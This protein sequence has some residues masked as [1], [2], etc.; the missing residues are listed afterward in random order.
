MADKMDR[1]AVDTTQAAPVNK[2][3]KFR[4]NRRQFLRQALAVTSGIAPWNCFRLHW[5]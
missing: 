2:E 3:E 4:A 5:W 1:Q